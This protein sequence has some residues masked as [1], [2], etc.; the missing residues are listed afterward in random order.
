MLIVLET[1]EHK[2]ID[3]LLVIRNLVLVN[4]SLIRNAENLGLSLVLGI[5]FFLV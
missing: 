5:V 4:C 2:S 3:S 1:V